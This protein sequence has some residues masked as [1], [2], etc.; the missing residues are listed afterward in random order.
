MPEMIMCEHCHEVVDAD[1]D[2]KYCDSDGVCLIC[3]Q[4]HFVE[5]ELCPVCGE[6]YIKPDEYKV[7]DQCFKK[8]STIDNAIRFGSEHPERIELNEYLAFEF[9]QFE[10]ER[11]LVEKLKQKKGDHLKEYL[12]D[13]NYDFQEWLIRN[14]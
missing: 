2:E 1:T 10:I 9:S 14:N 5:T 7:C 3:K 11:I 6:H 13:A 12:E 4:G 8:H